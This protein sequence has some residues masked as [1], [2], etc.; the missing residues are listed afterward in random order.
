M[1]KFMPVWSV[2]TPHLLSGFTEDGDIQDNTVYPQWKVPE[3]I[4]DSISMLVSLVE[5]LSVHC[6]FRTP[7]AS[8]LLST[9]SKLDLFKDFLTFS[10]F[11]A[12]QVSVNVS[13]SFQN[14]L[15]SL[16]KKWHLSSGCHEC[17]VCTVGFLWHCSKELAWEM[18]WWTPAT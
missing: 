7:W 3:Q 16:S 11:N 2:P 4:S 15:W 5:L 10:L 1:V 9:V 18:W 6:L 8:F 17:V 12:I 13:K 14:F